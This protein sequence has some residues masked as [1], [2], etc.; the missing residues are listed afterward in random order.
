MPVALRL[1]PEIHLTPEMC[2]TL[3]GVI[4]IVNIVQ[5]LLT[6]FVKSLINPWGLCDTLAEC[7]LC[8]P[9]TSVCGVVSPVRPWICVL[10]HSSLFWWVGVAFPIYPFFLKCSASVTSS[11]LVV[12]PAMKFIIL[13]WLLSATCY[14]SSSSCISTKS[15][16]E[17]E[18]KWLCWSI[19]HGLLTPFVVKELGWIECPTQVNLTNFHRFFYC[20]IRPRFSAYS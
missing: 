2:D 18:K 13:L 8:T 10:T 4:S 19:W 6:W 15:G 16:W 11:A 5:S 1:F 7:P 9:L 17:Q 12:V 14:N 3:S 20:Q